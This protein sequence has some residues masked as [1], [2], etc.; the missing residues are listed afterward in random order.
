MSDNLSHFVRLFNQELEF[1]G[2]T[3][4]LTINNTKGR[5]YKIY[6]VYHN[7]IWIITDRESQPT[8]WLD[9]TVIIPSEYILHNVT[10]AQF[11][12]DLQAH[13]ESKK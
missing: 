9:G 2:K 3:R 5:S 13:I 12:E 4:S 1:D 6:F 10:Y 7:N 8:G 11:K